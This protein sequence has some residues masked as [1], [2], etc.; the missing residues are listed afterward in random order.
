LERRYDQHEINE[1]TGAKG[2]EQK[3]TETTELPIVM[4]SRNCRRIV[5]DTSAFYIV[6]C[7]PSCDWDLWFEI[8]NLFRA[9][10]ARVN[11]AAQNF[12]GPAPKLK[13]PQG[14]SGRLALEV[15]SPGPEPRFY[16][17]Y[18]SG[19]QL[20]IKYNYA[21][22]LMN[23]WLVSNDGHKRTLLTRQTLTRATWAAWSVANAIFR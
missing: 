5:E 11:A 18:A 3:D 4:T 19:I 13:K 14:R 15:G 10:C 12:R 2:D 9:F 16:P 21:G 17:L 8:E 23:E 1:K 6:H 20:K 22:E 7:D